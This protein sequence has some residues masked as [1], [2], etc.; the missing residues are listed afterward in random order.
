MRLAPRSSSSRA[1][2]LP[3]S[4]SVRAFG[5]ATSNTPTR[6]SSTSFALRACTSARVAQRAL[7]RDGAREGEHEQ[8]RQRDPGAVPADELAQAVGRAVRAGEDGVPVQEALQV[9]RE[10]GRRLIPALRQL[11][12]R[13]HHDQIEIAAQ[14]AS[15]VRP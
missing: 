6:K 4:R 11:L 1:V 12:Q 7:S 8:H 10:R 3:P 13:G 14:P 15:R 2:M 5:S 9:L